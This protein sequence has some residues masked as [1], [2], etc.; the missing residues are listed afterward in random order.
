M[1]LLRYK[2]NPIKQ[3]MYSH[4]TTVQYDLYDK[5]LNYKSVDDW[6][7]LK[8]TSATGQL[9]GTSGYKITEVCKMCFLVSKHHSV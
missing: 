3:M 2:K 8:N 9:P 7:C 6:H 1:M 4:F 5:R